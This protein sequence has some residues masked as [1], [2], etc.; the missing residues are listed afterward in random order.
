[1][2][3][4]T[5]ITIG[6]VIAVLVAA[7]FGIDLKENH[8]ISQSQHVDTASVKPS[9]QANT[10]SQNISGAE[11]IRQAFQNKM[12]KVQVQSQGVVRA[13]LADDND[14]SRH[15]KF[16]LELNNGLTLLVA[17]NIDLAPRIPDI[18]K[19]DVVEFYGVY[20]YSPKGGVMHWTHK[21]LNKKHINGWL[22]HQN[23]TYS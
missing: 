5:N 10:S 8:A 9:E 2:A 20:E 22:K 16:I 15:Q 21:D 17:H 1:M 12:S 23:K 18:K 6:G 13:V 4:K 3:N 7:Y 14:G 11:V 19:G